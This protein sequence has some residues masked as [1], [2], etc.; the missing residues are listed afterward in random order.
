MCVLGRENVIFYVKKQRARK[1]VT[2]K[3]GVNDCGS[4]C[5]LRLREILKM[6]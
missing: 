2:K 6:Q 5:L 4:V 3:T 1:W